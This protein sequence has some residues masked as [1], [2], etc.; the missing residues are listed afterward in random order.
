[1]NAA[2]HHSS[3]SSYVRAVDGFIVRTI[4]SAGLEPE[5]SALVL[6]GLAAKGVGAEEAEALASTPRRSIRKPLSSHSL[7]PLYLAIRAH[8]ADVGADAE[9]LGAGLM[10]FYYAI[11]LFDSVQ[12]DEL[13]GPFGEAGTELS[14]NCA[15]TLL[16]L[17]QDALHGFARGLPPGHQGR[18]AAMIREHALRSSRGQHRDLVSRGHEI[19][20]SAARETSIEKSALCA[21][22]MELAGLYVGA[23]DPRYRVIGDAIAELRQLVNDVADLFDGDRSEDLRQGTMSMPLALFVE[24]GGDAARAALTQAR[25]QRLSEGEIQRR[26]HGAGVLERVAAQTEAVRVRLHEAFAG[27]PCSGPHLALLLASF[28]A[29]PSF[30]YRPRPLVHAVDIDAIDA[31]SMSAPDRALFEALRRERRVRMA[32]TPIRESKAS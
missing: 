30:Y 11:D 28:D 31:S 29:L 4:E 19:T 7:A 25:E 9:P 23:V 14:I 32:P 16:V 15:I 2:I 26:V 22:R 12:D 5:Q 3:L 20:A 10:L 27:L 24:Q 6:A 8:G 18:A 17:A 21:L 1:M 13:S